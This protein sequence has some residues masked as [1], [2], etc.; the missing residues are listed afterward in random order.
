MKKGT[1]Q[2]KSLKDA[3]QAIEALKQKEIEQFRKDTAVEVA[4]QLIKTATDR[5]LKNGSVRL[6]GKGVFNVPESVRNAA[7]PHLALITYLIHGASSNEDVDW[8]LKEVKAT[9]TRAFIAPENEVEYTHASK[10][11]HDNF[12]KRM[13]KKGRTVIQKYTTDASG[14]IVPSTIIDLNELKA[15]AKY[16]SKDLEDNQWFFQLFDK[17]RVIK[18]PAFDDKGKKVGEEDL[19]A[20]TVQQLSVLTLIAKAGTEGM[21]TADITN[22]L[23]TGLSSVQRQLGRLGSGYSFKSRGEAQDR[24]R[25]GLRLIEQF[26]NPLNRKQLRWVLTREGI[27]LF[28]QLNSVF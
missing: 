27:N 10:E 20:A 25:N 13:K 14:K 5:S 28:K 21:T 4:K 16:S 7:S 6:V 8:L 22:S 12:V 2:A 24:K 17:L 23:G 9:S 26:E 15:S 19:S 1:T 18:L 3:N 11:S